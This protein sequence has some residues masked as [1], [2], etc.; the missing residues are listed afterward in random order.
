[1]LSVFACIF[2]F[3]QLQM[4]MVLTALRST[5]QVVWLF[6]SDTVQ[7]DNY[8]QKAYVTLGVVG[9]LQGIER[10]RRF[11]DT[12]TPFVVGSL[13]VADFNVCGRYW[14]QFLVDSEGQL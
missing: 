6:F 10:Q 3:Q 7:P 9:N 11:H 12:F 1:M 8:V 13:A 4:Q 14:D 2:R 5:R